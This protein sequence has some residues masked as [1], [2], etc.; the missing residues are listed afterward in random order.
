MVRIYL[1]VSC[2]IRPDDDQQQ[3][4]I[5]LETEA[6]AIILEGCERGRW[7]QLASDMTVIE[8]NASED[9]ER[10]RR[11]LALLPD[12]AEIAPLD[13]AIWARAKDCQTMGFKSADAVHIA[14]AEAM[15]ADVLLTCDD[16]MLK[17]GARYRS[18]LH[19][20]ITNPLSW[21]EEY[22][23]DTNAG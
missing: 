18:R 13:D 6:I 4:R 9:A 17:R 1:D 19:V 3:A 23:N 8:I 2:L 15:D 5:R 7:V 22:D 20:V 16:R 10:H 11:A 21:L 14:A 12:A